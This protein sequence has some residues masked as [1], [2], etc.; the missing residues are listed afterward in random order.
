MEYNVHLFFSKET[1]Y[2]IGYADPQFLV[3]TNK[4]PQVSS[5]LLLVYIH[6]PHQLNIGSLQG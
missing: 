2:I 5:Y 1:I 3:Q 6:C 4:F